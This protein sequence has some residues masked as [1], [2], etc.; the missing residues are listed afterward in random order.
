MQGRR[1]LEVAQRLS[2][3]TEEPFLRTRVG[4]AYYSAYLEVRQFCEDHLHY[5]RTKSSREHQEV[6]AMIRSVDPDIVV[7]LALLR[8]YRND[9]DY[10]MNLTLDT[11]AHNVDDGEAFAREIIARLDELAAERAANVP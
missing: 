10:E 3:E 6:P 2:L 5:Q 8:K 7:K 4:R 11:L 1:F 9:A